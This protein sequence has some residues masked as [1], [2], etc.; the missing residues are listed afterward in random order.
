MGNQTNATRALYGMIS[1]WHSPIFIANTYSAVGGY[2]WIGVI[3][4]NRAMLAIDAL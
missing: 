4:T 1:L 3:Q 2:Q